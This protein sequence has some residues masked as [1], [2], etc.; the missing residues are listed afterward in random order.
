MIGSEWNDA[1]QK[2]NRI[3]K[4]DF[5]LLKCRVQQSTLFRSH[6]DNGYIRFAFFTLNIFFTCNQL[7][8][9]YMYKINYHWTLYSN[10]IFNPLFSIFSRFISFIW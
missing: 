7:L 10:F 9:Y 1:E 4:Y 3:Q 8:P 2:K 6:I 5:S